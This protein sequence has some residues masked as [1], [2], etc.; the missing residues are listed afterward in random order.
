MSDGRKRGRPI[1]TTN[2]DRA[3]KRSMAF[4]PGLYEEIK[5][6]ATQ[7]ERDVTSQIIKT[8]REFVAQYKAQRKDVTV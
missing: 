5:Q 2:P 4:P 8:L 1:G 6:I 3:H 7:E